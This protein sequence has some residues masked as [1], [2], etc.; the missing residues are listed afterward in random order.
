MEVAALDTFADKSPSFS[1]VAQKTWECL[2]VSEGESVTPLRIWEE[3]MEEVGEQ[4]WGDMVPELVIFV[5]T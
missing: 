5:T 2:G 3:E 4:S 1:L